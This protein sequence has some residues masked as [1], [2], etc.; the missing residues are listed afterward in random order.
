MKRGA[1]SRFCMGKVGAGS[2]W[3]L[4]VPVGILLTDASTI[5]AL[6]PRTDRYTSHVPLALSSFRSLPAFRYLRQNS[7]PQLKMVL[8]FGAGTGQGHERR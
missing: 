6:P 2:L 5:V 4:P 8:A 3:Q 1:A 7:W